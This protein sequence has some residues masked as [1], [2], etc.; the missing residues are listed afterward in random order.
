[1]AFYKWSCDIAADVMYDPP[2]GWPPTRA[3]YQRYHNSHVRL[4]GL[5]GI[6]CFGVVSPVDHE[7]LWPG[8]SG[9]VMMRLSIPMDAGPWMESALQ[10]G[11]GFAIYILYELAATGVITEMLEPLTP[12]IP[13]RA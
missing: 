12:I 13:R 11:Q 10:I 1:M 7:Y 4:D 6:D 8:E 2:A 3:I 5:P 9:V